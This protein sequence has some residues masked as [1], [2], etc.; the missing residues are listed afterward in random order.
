MI[1]GARVKWH[2]FGN[3]VLAKYKGGATIQE[4]QDYLKEYYGEDVGKSAIHGYLT[5]NNVKSHEKVN[6]EAELN[7]KRIHYEDFK[8]FILENEATKSYNWIAKEIGGVASG[9]KRKLK[10]WGEENE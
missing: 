3:D 2:L 10:L 6:R 9:V 7:R 1:M 5:R 8:D 4:I